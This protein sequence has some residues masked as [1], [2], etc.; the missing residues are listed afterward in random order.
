MIK[1]NGCKCCIVHDPDP[2]ADVRDLASPVAIVFVFVEMS[3][4]CLT[5]RSQK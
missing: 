1:N 3:Q 2:A 4:P 5:S